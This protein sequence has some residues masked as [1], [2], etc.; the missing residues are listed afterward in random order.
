MTEG[1]KTKI[2]NDLKVL[3]TLSECITHQDKRVA[4]LA[5]KQVM[6]F[7]ENNP[8]QILL[9]FEKKSQGIIHCIDCYIKADNP[10]LQQSAS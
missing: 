1:E 7:G 9:E 2:D 8:K 5:L 4:E 6:I 3:S 10:V